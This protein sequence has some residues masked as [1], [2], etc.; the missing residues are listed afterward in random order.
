[1]AVEINAPACASDAF[2]A[3]FGTPRHALI[4]LA[5]ALAL[6]RAL[7]IGCGSGANLAEIRRRHPGCETVGLELHP[8][9]AARARQRAGIDR[10]VEGDVLDHQRVDFE[11]AGFDLI[12]LSHVLEHF[13]QP[14]QVL[15]R[16]RRWLQPGGHL[17][18]ALPNLRHGAVLGELLF[19]GDFRYREHGV[20]DRTHLRFYTRTSAI[21]FLREQGFEPLRVAPDVDGRR[22]KLL[23][24][25]SF[26]LAHEFAA[27]A[28]N[29]LV[30]AR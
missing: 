17:L 3:Y 15:A 11:P 22:W 2:D 10:L 28:Y 26:G 5:D 12:V 20:L 18:I 9:A 21:R 1:M 29:F 30:A 6:R 25:A 7:E 8:D 23:Q 14:E 24:R 19:G 16:C 4:D 13:A 27:F